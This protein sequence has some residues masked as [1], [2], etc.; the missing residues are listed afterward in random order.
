LWFLIEA[1]QENWR[2][3]A[4]KR[5]SN[6]IAR[7]PES[8]TACLWARVHLLSFS[9]SS[10]FFASFVRTLTFTYLACFYF[11]I[12]ACYFFVVT[13]QNLLTLLGFFLLVLG[14]SSGSGE[15][16]IAS[17]DQDN[18]PFLREQRRYL[19][20]LPTPTL[21]SCIKVSA[22]S[23]W[24]FELSFASMSGYIK[25]VE[26]ANL[27]MCTESNQLHCLYRSLSK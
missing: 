24:T 12:F 3:E 25:T 18:Q 26:F 10:I 5:F 20:Y 21:D 14:Y 2:C 22:A 27:L 6:H 15:Y 17:M 19:C 11:L 13:F 16:L 7:V 1:E 9:S 8:P 23:F 4:S